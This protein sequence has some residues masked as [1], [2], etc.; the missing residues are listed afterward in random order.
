ERTVPTTGSEEIRLYMR[1]YYSLLRTTDEVQIQTLVESHLGMDSVLHVKSRAGGVDVSALVY[2]SLRLPPCIRR[3]RLV[4]MGQS[5]RVFARRGYSN[6]EQWQPVAAAARRRRSFF[7][8]RETLAVYVAS[9]SDVDDLIPILTAFQI[10]W[11]KIHLRL[12]GHSLLADLEACVEGGQSA[13]ADKKQLFGKIQNPVLATSRKMKDTVGVLNA[14][15]RARLCETLSISDDDLS[16][17]E[18]IWKDDFLAMLLDAGRQR[19]RMAARLLAGSQVEYRKATQRWWENIAGNL[20]FDPGERPVYFISSNTH[21]VVNILSGFALRREEELVRFLREGGDADLQTEYADIQAHHVPSNRENFLY[22]VLKKYLQTP[23]GRQA[24]KDREVEE[25]LC[26]I[27]HI[28]S[29]HVFDIAT[30][31]VEL[32]ALRLDWLDSRLRIPG[33]E[34][35]AHSDAIIINIDYP[36][37]MGAYHILSQIAASVESLQGVYALGK[38]ATLNGRIGDVM[39]PNVVHDEHSRNTYLFNN[40][41][42]AAHVSPYLVYGTALDNQRAISVRGTFLQNQRYM[43]AFYHEGYTDIE[44]ETGPYLS[45]VYEAMRPRRYP[46]DEIVNLY[47]IPFDI[48]VIHYASDTPFS[49]GQNLGAQHLSYFGMDPTYAATVAILRRILELEI[50]NISN[51]SE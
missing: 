41:F 43:D 12:H 45:A 30:Q 27:R 32:R 11:N 35:I 9:L 19:K 5:E 42:S 1:T 15:L 7:D 3:T 47:P 22:Y 23:S 29:R 37:G 38:A 40:A 4:V 31:I 14:D 46:R 33:I 13:D 34:R 28:D 17:L 8:G 48:G 26:G 39:I 49:K 16:Q 36:L 24:W 10:E 18:A 21:S 2:S 50:S 51:D 6:V 44:M 20:P 25:P